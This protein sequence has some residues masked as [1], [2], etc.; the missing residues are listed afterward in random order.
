MTVEI[1]T[2]NCQHCR[3]DNC[4]N[5]LFPDRCRC[6]YFKHED[7][8][9]IGVKLS[10]EKVSE[11]KKL[12]AQMQVYE[13]ENNLN[14][15]GDAKID[16]VA[17]TL[18]H[19]FKFVTLRKTN[20]ILLYNG[21]IYDNLQAETIIKEQTEKLIP[22][23]T[24]HNR[25]EVI[26]KIKAQT[27]TDLEKFDADPN[28]ITVLN[29]ILNLETLE[30]E[31]H[32]PNHLS[33]VLLPV[34][35][36]KPE[37]DDIEENLKDTLFWKYLKSSF[38][39]NGKFRQEDF[40]TVLEIIASPIVKRHV[41]EKAF[42][43]LGNGENGKSVCLGYI[44][45]ILG[46][47][48]VSAISLQKLTENKFMASNLSGKSAN[49]FPDLEEYDLKNPSI[50]KAITTNEGIEVERKYQQGFTLHPF[51]KLIFSCNRFPKSF[52]QG[53]GFFRRWMIVKWE[54]DF[55]ND[56]ERIEY[57]R[58]KLDD[59]QEEKNKVFSCLVS[60][61][62]RLNKDGK[63]T[64]TKDWKTVRKEWNENA[65]PIDDFDSNYILDSLTH[66]TKIETYHFYK[67]IM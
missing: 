67:Q 49:I 48:N 36:H 61:A 52:D 20:E 26:N 56:P 47:N 30:L 15:D 35:Y 53:H 44:K 19:F 34:E 12:S 5:C 43:F 50:I 16:H 23:C 66:K 55:E 45:S 22:N 31:P 25:S 58:E 40:E 18:R 8:L 27:F 51:C 1:P 13:V 38:T 2:V 63:F 10:S 21:K 46:E 4:D 57:L 11:E 42:M 14:F 9:K 28:L 29:G 54:R 62:N 24:S 64:H 37:H 60:I 33:R 17:K 41:D 39:V 7:D 32:N 59:N 65:D 3:E 6:A